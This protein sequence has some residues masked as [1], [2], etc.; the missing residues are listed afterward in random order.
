MMNIK[1]VNGFYPK[2]PNMFVVFVCIDDTGE[3]M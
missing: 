1:L 3:L 2:M